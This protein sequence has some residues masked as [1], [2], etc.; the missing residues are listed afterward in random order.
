MNK[1]TKRFRLK[2]KEN[3]AESYINFI[4]KVS[5]DPIFKR[6]VDKAIFLNFAIVNNCC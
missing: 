3:R 1:K 2:F 4:R 6:R 5:T